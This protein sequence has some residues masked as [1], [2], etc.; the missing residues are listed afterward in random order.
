LR[1]RERRREGKGKRGRER[2]RWR[3]NIKMGSAYLFYLCALFFSIEF[4]NLNLVYQLT[5]EIMHQQRERE[6]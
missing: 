1:E 5:I 4:Q 2:E 3:I 6:R